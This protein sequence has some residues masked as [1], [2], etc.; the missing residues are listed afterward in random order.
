MRRCWRKLGAQRLR[1]QYQYETNWGAELGL[2]FDLQLRSMA[3]STRLLARLGSGNDGRVHQRS[4]AHLCTRPSTR[5][6]MRK[7]SGADRR[8]GTR[9][10]CSILQPAEVL[11]TSPKRP[12]PS[13]SPCI[14][15]E[16]VKRI[17]G[18]IFKAAKAGSCESAPGNRLFLSGSRALDP[19]L[20]GGD[21]LRLSRPNSRCS[22]RVAEQVARTVVSHGMSSYHAAC[23]ERTW[24]W[25][26]T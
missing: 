1:A 25:Q 14:A 2:G 4:I 19:A 6:R 5:S 26:A 23:G 21:D 3:T 12:P 18:Y 15:Q 9:E 10:P 20:A 24:F 11:E 22:S 13:S 17:V 8:V 16:M 7:R